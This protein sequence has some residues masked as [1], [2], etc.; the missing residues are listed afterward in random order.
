MKKLLA[1]LCVAALILGMLA[2][3]A[4]GGGSDGGNS[5]G[6]KSDGGKSSGE[7]TDSGSSK[8]D[9]TITIVQSSDIIGW[10]PCASAD[11]NTKNCMKNLLNRTFETDENLQPVPI[12]I[13]SYEQLDDLN[14]TFT[15]KEG[16]KFFDGTDCT[17]DDV[18][19]SIMRARE[20]SSS[21]KSLYGPI[22]EFN[23]VDART[24]T[25]KTTNVYNSLPTALSNTSGA[26]LSQE[27]VEKAP[28][29]A[30]GKM[31]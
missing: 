6:G 16:I 30:H 8:W 5:E 27:W 21:G 11:V 26:V 25:I 31:L 7:K 2:G 29:P 14:W 19:F 3:C 9:G 15:L 28:A 13:E 17:A 12:M 20:T 18:K 22:E 1:I 10:D 4:T 24:F 23:V